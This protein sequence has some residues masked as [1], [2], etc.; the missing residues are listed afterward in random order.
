MSMLTNACEMLAY[1][2]EQLQTINRIERAM[3]I[4]AFPSDP[5]GRA[6]IVLARASQS[7]SAGVAAKMLTRCVAANDSTITPE[8]A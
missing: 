8:V 2:Q 1:A 5:I 3:R 6:R 4:G 7:H